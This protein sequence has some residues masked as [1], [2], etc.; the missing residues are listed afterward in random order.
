MNHRT[1]AEW[2]KDHGRQKQRASSTERNPSLI[3]SLP[4]NKLAVFLDSPP[5]V[6]CSEGRRKETRAWPTPIA[7]NFKMLG[8]ELDPVSD[9]LFL[10]PLPYLGNNPKSSEGIKKI[11]HKAPALTTA[12]APQVTNFPKCN[13]SSS[14]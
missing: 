5:F 6:A 11:S 2:L 9:F 10:S 8:E 13:C 4:S 7:R 1:E 3:F 12:S 14:S